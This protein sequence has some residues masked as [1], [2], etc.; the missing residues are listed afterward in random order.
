MA[1][2]REPS[3][4]EQLAAQE[5]ADVEAGF[6]GVRPDPTPLHHYTVPGVLAEKPT[7]ETD[8]KLAAD[9]AALQSVEKEV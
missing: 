1:A 2:K 8:D 6:R 5:A 7:P 3:A 4:E 9:A